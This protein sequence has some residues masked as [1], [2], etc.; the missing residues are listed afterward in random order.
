MHE[1][2][3]S[4]FAKLTENYKDKCMI[5][6]DDLTVTNLDRL[7]KAI[8]K[9]S[10]N[11]M[12]I[13]PNQNGS[14]LDTAEVIKEAKKNK[15]YLIISHRSGETLDVSISHLAVGYKLPMIKCGV[16]GKERKV[17]LSEISKIE[18]QIKYKI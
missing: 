1:E 18:K 11:A 10:I 2:D 3:F 17:K 5:C 4:G 14:L 9:K 12:I 8:N 7:R 15:L 13:K 6:G 16:Y